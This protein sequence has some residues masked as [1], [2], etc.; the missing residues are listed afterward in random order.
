MV[1]RGRVEEGFEAEGVSMV[2]K[3]GGRGR[4]MEL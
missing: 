1:V 3:G 2:E 4:V